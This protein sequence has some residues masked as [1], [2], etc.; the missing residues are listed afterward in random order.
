MSSLFDDLH[1][2]ELNSSTDMEIDDLLG[3]LSVK[4]SGDKDIEQVSSLTT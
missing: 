3:R 2:D 4:E 1:L